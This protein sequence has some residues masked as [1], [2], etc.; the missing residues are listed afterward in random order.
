M[1]SSVT[2]LN[3]K[4]AEQTHVKEQLLTLQGHVKKK[5]ASKI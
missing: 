1:K 3:G 5:L 4:N 2:F